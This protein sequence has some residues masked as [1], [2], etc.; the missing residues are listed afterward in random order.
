MNERTEADWWGAGGNNYVTRARDVSL[1][2]VM[3]ISR[4]IR[5]D[6][7]PAG[8]IYNGDESRRS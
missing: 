7:L 4:G 3:V 2:E 1:C 5:L 6:G 8:G